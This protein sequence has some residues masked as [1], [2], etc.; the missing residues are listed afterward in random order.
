M[1]VLNDLKS[2]HCL[3]AVLT[4]ELPSED[5]CCIPFL[6]EHLEACIPPTHELVNHSALS[7]SDLDSHHFLL[8]TRLRF[9]DAMCRAKMP[10][11]RF[12]VQPDRFSLQELIR[13]SALPCFTTN[14]S[15]QI[16]EI[17]ENRIRIPIADPDANV[18]YHAVFHKKDKYKTAFTNLTNNMMSYRLEQGTV[19]H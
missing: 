7:F 11:S 16:N 18:T 19:K 17:P 14:L 9:W 3:M 15:D 2:G 12:L 4:E 8:G 10:A 1:D 13:E 6:K 5:Y